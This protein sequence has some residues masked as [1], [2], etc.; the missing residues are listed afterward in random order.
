MRL[1]EKVREDVARLLA[2][3]CTDD[4]DRDAYDFALKEL[5]RMAIL[6][7]L[8]AGSAPRANA[9]SSPPADNH[10]ED[11]ERWIAR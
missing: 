6:G 11:K 4:T 7:T 10:S 5:T 2:M 9:P 1:E 3:V 8:P